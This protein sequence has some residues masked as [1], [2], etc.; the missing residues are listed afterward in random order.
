MALK[1]VWCW[2][3]RVAG[4]VGVAGEAT[5]QCWLLKQQQSPRNA[6]G[7]PAVK[8]AR[9]LARTVKSPVNRGFWL[10]ARALQ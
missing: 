1:R 5:R 9:L 7:R 2:V 4:V 3:F 6:A 10:L 8:V